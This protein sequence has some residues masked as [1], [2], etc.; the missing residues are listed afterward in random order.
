MNL[1]EE[2][3]DEEETGERNTNIGSAQPS[4]PLILIL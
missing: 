3:E 1:E 2:D 4:S